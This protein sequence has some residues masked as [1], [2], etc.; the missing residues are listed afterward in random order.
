VKHPKQYKMISSSECT[1]CDNK[2]VGD[3]RC[4][5]TFPIEDASFK[6]NQCMY[7]KGHRGK[8]SICGSIIGHHPIVTWK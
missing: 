7:K 5:V 1:H 8:H 3:K 6:G 4:E 2:Y